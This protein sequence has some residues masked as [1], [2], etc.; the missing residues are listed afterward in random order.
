MQRDP[1]QYQRRSTQSR[2][3]SSKGLDNALAIHRSIRILLWL[4]QN[5]VTIGSLQDFEF[6]DC[7][8][9]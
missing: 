2:S 5:H 3:A 8:C 4:F 1:R 7:G 6:H 9:R